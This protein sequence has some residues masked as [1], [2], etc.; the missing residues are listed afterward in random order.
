M[1]LCSCQ[2]NDG[3]YLPY[4]IIIQIHS[5]QS[6]LSHQQ[7]HL[8]NFTNTSS[9]LQNFLPP[10]IAFWSIAIA[11]IA[12]CVVA[13]HTLRSGTLLTSYVI[14]CTYV[15]N[16]SKLNAR[17]DLLWES[18]GP[19]KA[20]SSFRSFHSQRSYLINRF[21]NSASKNCLK[22]FNWNI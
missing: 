18:T 19:K 13:R 15:L 8:A 4:H 1:V 20:S 14:V 10:E 6:K 17:C 12:V 5:T 9:A 7:Y 22:K 11:T 3:R 16:A 21:S 2:P